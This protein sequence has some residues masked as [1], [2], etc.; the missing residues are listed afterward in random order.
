VV[1]KNAWEGLKMDYKDIFDIVGALV[2]FSQ[3][4]FS[5]MTTEISTPIGDYNL[6]FLLGGGLLLILIAKW[7]IF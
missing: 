3:K 7:V 2:V 5:L 6:I 1:I 4:V